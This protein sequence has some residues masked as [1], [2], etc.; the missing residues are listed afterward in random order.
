MKVAFRSKTSLT[1]ALLLLALGALSL[2]GCNTI[3][4]V[5]QDLQ[6]AGRAVEDA[7]DR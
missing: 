1:T 6:S 5:G 3:E 7:A 4:G 2:T